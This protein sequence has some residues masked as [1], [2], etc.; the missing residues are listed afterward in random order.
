MAAFD[1]DMDKKED[2]IVGAPLERE[3]GSEERRGAIYIFYGN[4]ELR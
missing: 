4:E 3:E 2:L 1:L